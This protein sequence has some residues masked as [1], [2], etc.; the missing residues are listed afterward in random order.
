MKQTTNLTQRSFE[1]G[2]ALANLCPDEP[3]KADFLFELAKSSDADRDQKIELARAALEIMRN[4][5]SGLYESPTVWLAER[6][7]DVAQ[8]DENLSREFLFEAYWSQTRLTR[9]TPFHQTS[10]L[11]QH[12]ARIDAEVARALVEP[13]FDDWSW[14]FGDRDHEVIF[15]N[16]DPLNVAAAIDPEWATNLIDELFSG[17][18]SEHRSRKLA[19]IHGVISSLAE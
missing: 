16:I 15:G 1:R 2:M 10:A 11:A 17:H 6:V 5:S 3:G 14:L 13:C 19:V 4:D 12:T 7:K 8:W 9:I 18:L